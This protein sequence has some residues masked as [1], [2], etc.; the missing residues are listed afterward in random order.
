MSKRR[1]PCAAAGCNVLVPLGQSMCERHAKVNAAERV[2]AQRTRWKKR[3]WSYLYKLAG[4]CGPNG[5]RA[6]QLK[7]QPLCEMCPPGQERLASVVDHKIPHRGNRRLFFSKSN[8][9]SLCP[10]CHNST[11]QKI[12][13]RDMAQGGGW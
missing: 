3:E 9:Q 7:R 8:V 1:K 6:W 11:K 5:L 2:E 10:H 13:R 12:E 4:W